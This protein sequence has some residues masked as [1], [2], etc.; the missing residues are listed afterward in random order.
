[1]SGCHH[2][3]G[4]APLADGRFRRILWIALVVNA[5][6]FVIEIGVSQLS[7]SMALQ[8]DAL[9]FLGDSFN[10][11]ISLLVLPLGLAMRA[12]AAYFKG[13]CMAGFGVWVLAI[14]LWRAFHGEAPDAPLMGSTALLALAANV[15]VAG[16]LFRYRGGDSNMRSVW[17]C[18][19]ND[20]LVNI[21]VLLAASGV[22]VTG[23]RWPDLLVAGVI[24]ALALHS[25]RDV[26]RQSR[27]E[28]R[29]GRAGY[30]PASVAGH[31]D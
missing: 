12:R 24:A 2:C 28:I 18:S 30:D 11:A 5:A 31:G 9:D 14:T 15:G 27:T 6:M 20:A 4:D 22:F 29:T 17:L 21:A 8:A 13:V 3:P 1:M 25:A 23:T 26:L 16:L 10:Y 7:G 19:R